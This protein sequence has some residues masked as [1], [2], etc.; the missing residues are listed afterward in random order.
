MM[1]RDGNL[2]DTTDREADRFLEINSCGEQLG[3]SDYTCLRRRG[4]RDYL[5]LLITAGRCEVEYGEKCYSLVAG[6]FVL[7]PPHLPQRYS[8]F[9]QAGSCFCHFSGKS[10]AALLEDC[11]LTGGVYHHSN[12]RSVHATFCELMERFHAPH[13]SRYATATL[14]ELL[15]RLCEQRTAQEGPQAE[16]E[17]AIL[18]TLSYLRANYQKEISLGTLAAM[19]GYSK[20]RFSHLFAAVTQTTP[21]RYQNHL[22]L[23]ASCELLESTT[24]PIFEIAY[25]CGFADPLYYSRLFRQRYGLSPTDYRRRITTPE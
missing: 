9:E 1:I 5:I 2:L 20:S 12:L 16:Q 22:R 17:R 11:G 8:F 4:R 10:A 21:L 14:L 18:T 6:D 13:R 25:A 19:A 3:L 24:L 15:Y 7:Y 23:Q